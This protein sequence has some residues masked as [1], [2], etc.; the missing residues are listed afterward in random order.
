MAKNL[1]VPSE[2]N[3]DIRTT[4]YKISS[5]ETDLS[6]LFTKQALSIFLIKCLWTNYLRAIQNSIAFYSYVW[7]YFSGLTF[8]P[9]LKK[10]L[11]E[12]DFVVLC[13]PLTDQTRHLIS[14]QELSLMKPTA[15][16]INVGRGGTVNHNDLTA[17]LQNGVISGAA[18]DVTEPIKLP[19]DHPLLSMP[20]VIIT[21]HI[22][23]YAETTLKKMYSA[24]LDNLK[25]GVKGQQ[26]LYS[27]N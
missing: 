14:S 5:K 7:H 12:S 9:D 8:C 27:V 1:E 4:C 3:F 11:E 13:L 15:H 19:E 22:A 18:L 10:L 17:A 16:L 23:T 6:R 20:N 21:P 25:A 2:C 26:L 24:T